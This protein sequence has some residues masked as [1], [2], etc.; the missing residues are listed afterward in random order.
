MTEKKD[1]SFSLPQKVGDKYSLDFIASKDLFTQ[2]SS[3]K[4]LKDATM[5]LYF[6]REPQQPGSKASWMLR[7]FVFNEVPTLYI[8]RLSATSDF[9][10]QVSLTLS[11]EGTLSISSDSTI[12][13]TEKKFQLYAFAPQA[14]ISGTPPS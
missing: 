12:P 6:Q 9:T 13:D 14:D 3:T 10:D 11:P 7:R 4:S 5:R 8:G 1:F 2:P